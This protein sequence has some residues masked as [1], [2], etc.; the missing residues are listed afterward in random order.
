MHQACGESSERNQ[1]LAMQRF[2]LVGLHPARHVRQDY[3]A[4]RRAAGENSPELIGCETNQ[5]GVFGCS[6]T[7][8]KLAL[9][10]EQRGF[11][12]TVS[13]V[14]VA[15]HCA[16]AVS[17]FH[18]LGAGFSPQDHPIGIGWIAGLS[19]NCASL[20]A[21]PLHAVNSVD[22]RNIGASED[23]RF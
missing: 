20:E 18:L 12:N 17:S 23:I 11:G 19:D 6:E 13:R 10:S 9:A 4:R 21:L 14:S 16:G 8:L 1:L 5:L 3:L 7:E 15:Y 22:G 2:D